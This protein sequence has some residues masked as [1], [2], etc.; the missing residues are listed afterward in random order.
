MLA[1]S[2]VLNL[3]VKN[4]RDPSKHVFHVVTDRMNLGAM[5]VMFK[6]KDYKGAH[7][8]V[9]CFEDYELFLCSSALPA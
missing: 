8:E 2:V 4:A 7:I 1:A 9:K 6:L 3:A 5:Q